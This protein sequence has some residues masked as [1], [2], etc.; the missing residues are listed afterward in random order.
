MRENRRRNGA[1]RISK[2]LAKAEINAGRRKVCSLMKEENLK[3]IQSK[4]FKPRTT[5]SKGT[6]ATPNLL[7]EI[8]LEECASSENHHRRHHLHSSQR[9]QVLLFGNMAG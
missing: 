6:V 2:A 7:A 3:A 5:D 1:R 8:K 9:R 4:S